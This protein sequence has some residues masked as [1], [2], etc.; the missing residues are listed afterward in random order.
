MAGI[1]LNIPRVGRQDGAE[2]A[3]RPSRVE[4]LGPGLQ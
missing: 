4:S 1:H 2:L 3:F